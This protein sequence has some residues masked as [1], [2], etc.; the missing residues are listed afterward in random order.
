MH[1][2]YVASFVCVAIDC[3]LKFIWCCCSGITGANNRDL[4]ISSISDL[5]LES[6]EVK[7]CKMYICLLCVVRSDV[8]FA[9]IICGCNY[10][11]ILCVCCLYVL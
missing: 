4:F 8:S 2:V 1:N 11:P 10:S 9:C 7:Y 6:R 5:V 3:W